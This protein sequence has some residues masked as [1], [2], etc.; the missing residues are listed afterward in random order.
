MNNIEREFKTQISLDQ[1]EF[2]INKYDLKDKIYQ[3]T[4]YYFDTSDL[5][6]K[7]DNKTLR[8]RIKDISIHLTFKE[9]VID[10]FTTNVN[11]G[12]DGVNS[13]VYSSKSFS[14]NPLRDKIIAAKRKKIEEEFD[15]DEFAKEVDLK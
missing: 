15:P 14:N 12:F 6:L 8:I 4:N 3:Q 13:G 2:L 5:K 7:R 1:Y 10:K 11:S 9:K